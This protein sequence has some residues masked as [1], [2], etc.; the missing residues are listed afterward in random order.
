MEKVHIPDKRANSNNP[1]VSPI[2]AEMLCIS[3]LFE[4]SKIEH[5]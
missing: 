5:G 3:Q 4:F 1:E 2:L